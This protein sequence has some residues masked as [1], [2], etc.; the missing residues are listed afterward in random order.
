MRA[1]HVEQHS[2]IG[3]ETLGITNVHDIYWNLPTPALY[4]E[5]IRRREGVVSHLGPLAVRTGH[6]TGRS[7][8]DKFTVHEPSSASHIWWGKVNRPFDAD[9]FD[10]LHRRM[11]AYLQ[12]KDVF[13]QDCWAGADPKYRLP[14]RIVTE[15]AWH[16]LFARNLFIQASA[17]EMAEHEPEFTLIDCPRFHAISETDGTNSEIF[18]IV[19]FAKRLI[20]IGGTSYAG[21]IKKSIFTVMNYLLPFKDVLPMHCS[22]NYGPNGNTALF[23]GLSG[24]GKTTLSADSSRTLIGDD[25]HGW[26]DTGIFNFEGGCYAKLIRLSPEAEPEIYATTRRFGTILENVGVDN[27][28]RYLDL[29]DDSLTEN[30]RGA[31]HISSIPHAAPDGRGGHPKN[32]IFLTADAFGVMPPISKLTPEQTMYHFLSGYTAKVAGTEKGITEPSATFSTCFGAPFMAQHPSVYAKMLGRKISQHQANC[33]LVNTGWSGGPYG[34]GERMKIAYTRAMINAALNSHLKDVE[35]VTDPVF[36]V[37]VPTACPG[38]PN[39]VLIPRNTWQDCTAY[40]Q[41]AQKL[42]TMFVE[43]FKEFE[44]QV[45]DAVKAAA[46]RVD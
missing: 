19:N 36:G 28:T 15:Y 13:V 44:D 45:S 43:N 4:E 35:Y 2:K 8:N 37:Q 31:Y 12:L 24:T 10:E 30:T 7:P 5:A 16:S 17:E 39:E 21:E 46:P 38:V 41:Q 6:H 9:R 22:A 11:V 29:N 3:L 25:E 33:W 34:V 23:F 18:I 14:I 20:L 27:I 1:N 42:A 32:I 26:S 40:D